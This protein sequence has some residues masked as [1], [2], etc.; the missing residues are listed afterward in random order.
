MVRI[1]TRLVHRCTVPRAQ[2]HH[3]QSV[4]GSR[5]ASHQTFLILT[6]ATPFESTLERLPPH[7]RI[8][9]FYS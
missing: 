4:T 3:N 5:V 8:L 7:P 1:S 2:H 9:A 6:H